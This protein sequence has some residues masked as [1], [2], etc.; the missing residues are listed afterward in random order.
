M[1]ERRG[2]TAYSSNMLCSD[3]FPLQSTKR[4]SSSA[5]GRVTS[6]RS[7]L[8][9]PSVRSVTSSETSPSQPSRR[10]SQR[11]S[12]R[13]SIL[14]ISRLFDRRK[15]SEDSL[16]FSTAPQKTNARELYATAEITE[17][18]I[19]AGGPYTPSCT[20][21]TLDEESFQNID[22]FT[23]SRDSKSFF[24][25]FTDFTDSP[26][27]SSRKRESFLSFSSDH[28]FIPVPRL[29]RRD[30]PMSMPAPSP[31]RR[32]SEPY[33]PLSWVIS[34]H[35]LASEEVVPDLPLI[36]DATW[37]DPAGNID[38]RQFHIELLREEAA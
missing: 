20:S 13:S 8:I 26:A 14:S 12:K 4:R 22:P 3:P 15:S 10:S 7:S 6:W 32:S 27:P 18:W 17:V 37:V 21:K 30:R 1:T 31:S 2:P 36:E 23:S 35:L 16:A 29:F 9:F 11:S 25:D 38:W 5:S 19:T 28:S 24:M 33:R 34:D